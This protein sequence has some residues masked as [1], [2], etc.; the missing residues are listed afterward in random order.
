M[1]YVAPFN[2]TIK[3]SNP[4]M[5]ITVLQGWS[6]DFTSDMF[7]SFLFAPAITLVSIRSLL[8]VLF[9]SVGL[10]WQNDTGIKPNSAL[11]QDLM[12]KFGQFP[13]I[14]ICDFVTRFVHLNGEHD[15]R[16]ITKFS[17]CFQKLFKFDCS[18]AKLIKTN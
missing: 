16:I 14:L 1:A 17:Y 8:G 2:N 4:R 13:G 3:I 15:K 10:F 6:V 5:F 7:E 12:N 9:I 11:S 18:P